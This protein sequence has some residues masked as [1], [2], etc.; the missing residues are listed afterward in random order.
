MIR[1]STEHDIGR[2]V[3]I[4]LDGS[5]RA[6]HFI[7]RDYWIS[8][9]EEMAQ[10]YLPMAETY[11]EDEGNGPVGFLSLVDGYL[12]ALFVD[13]AHAGQG[14]GRKL[15]EYAT[16]LKPELELKVYRDN[17]GACRFYARNGFVVR[18][19]TV[20]EATGAREHVMVWKRADG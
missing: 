5:I 18:E 15:L 14:I 10:V 11:V 4:W 17:A 12:A 9:K 19:E 8:K 3:D 1:K 7:D 6:H 2:L 16:T 20:D 13:S